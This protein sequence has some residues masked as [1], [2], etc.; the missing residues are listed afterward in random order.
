MC[1]KL[2]F[3]ILLAVVLSLS[4][5]APAG[6]V[7]HWAFDDGSGAVAADDSGNGH[8]GTVTGAPSSIGT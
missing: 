8:A 2:T 1:K 3:A 5:V 7:A 4:S 6:V